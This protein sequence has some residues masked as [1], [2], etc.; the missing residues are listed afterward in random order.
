MATFIDRHAADAL[1][2]E[3]VCRLLDEADRHQL[4]ETGVRLVGHWVGDAHL[5]C[6]QEAVDAESV[7][8]H[9]AERGLACDDLHEIRTLHGVS[10]AASGDVSELV[11][12]AI[13]RI[14]PGEDAASGPPGPQ[15]SPEVRRAERDQSVKRILVVD[16]EEPIR[17]TVAEAL[18]D[19]GYDVLTAPDGAKALELVRAAEPDGVVLDLMMPVLDGWGFLQACRQERLCASTPVLVLSAYRKLADAVPA[20]VRVDRVLAKPFELDVLLEAVQELVA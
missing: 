19:E 16:D 17:T 10:A 14:W 20:E 9:H 1:P 18:A 7:R 8:R 11:R 2:S 4:D 13:A 6:V 12:D 5:H 3:T 15:Q